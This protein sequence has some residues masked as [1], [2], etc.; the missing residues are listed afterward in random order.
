MNTLYFLLTSCGLAVIIAFCS[1]VDVS[2]AQ[3]TPDPANFTLQANESQF[4]RLN[5]IF[6]TFYITYI[7]P[8]SKGA[9]VLV[10]AGMGISQDITVLPFSTVP[11]VPYNCPNI[12]SAKFTNLGPGEVN[13][14]IKE[15]QI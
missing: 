2:F 9:E 11:D 4:V 12:V 1:S 15:N 3:T 13:I 7:S 14:Q 10:E 6:Q 8:D 5:P